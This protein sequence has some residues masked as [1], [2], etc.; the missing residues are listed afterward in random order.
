MGADDPGSLPP[1]PERDSRAFL[2]GSSAHPTTRS[3]PGRTVGTRRVDKWVRPKRTSRNLWNRLP[4]SSFDKKSASMWLGW[5]YRSVMWSVSS[6]SVMKKYRI[7]IWRDRWLAD[8]RPFLIQFPP[9][10]DENW[11]RYELSN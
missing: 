11:L 1:S 9:K 7:L 10:M 6:R 4:W 5:E 3:S 2:L 8:A